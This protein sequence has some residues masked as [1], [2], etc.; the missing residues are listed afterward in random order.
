[1][2]PDPPTV[3]VA[4]SEAASA[5]P[6][7]WRRSDGKLGGA[8]GDEDGIG[9]VP[10]WTLAEAL[11]WE[12]EAA[13][14]GAGVGL[15]PALRATDIINRL[16]FATPGV[17]HSLGTAAAEYSPASGQDLFSLY[18]LEG[19]LRSDVLCRPKALPKGSLLA[20][21]LV[22]EATTWHTQLVELAQLV[23]EA[24]AD[25][26]P[27]LRLHWAPACVRGHGDLHAGNVLVGAGGVAF[28]ARVRH[29]L[30]HTQP[31]GSMRVFVPFPPSLL[32]S[33]LPLS[34][35]DRKSLMQSSRL[36]K[37]PRLRV[38]CEISPGRKMVALA[39][40]VTTEGQHS[41]TLWVLPAAA[42][43]RAN[44]MRVRGF[45]QMGAAARREFPQGAVLRDAARV[46][47]S[48]LFE[49][50]ALPLTLDELAAAPSAAAAAGWLGVPEP[51][52]AA[53]AAWAASTEVSESSEADKEAKWYTWLQRHVPSL[54]QRRLLQRLSVSKGHC[55]AYLHQVR[56]RLGTGC[57][58]PERRQRRLPRLSRTRSPP[59]A[60][61]HQSSS[62]NTRTPSRYAASSPRDG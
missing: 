6:P 43:H 39:K 4:P 2:P 21:P 11:A 46:E 44:R 15:E 62:S 37:S 56:T 41:A 32:S 23:V 55:W 29:S 8:D 26:A 17:L 51:L 5:V 57:A 25:R 3:A 34:L 12:M 42:A 58:W 14:G 59:P 61:P 45:G 50:T 40:A 35:A 9:A 28:A 30:A 16:V 7:V 31:P 33:P 27:N 54:W 20:N 47:A 19:V 13:V 53:A 52:A 1:V 48:L 10:V 38:Q 60:P 18:G 49:A 24:V 36:A 22:L